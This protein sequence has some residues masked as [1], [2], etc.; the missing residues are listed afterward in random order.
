[1]HPSLYGRL[2]AASSA[3]VTL[4]NGGGETLFASLAAEKGG[5]ALRQDAVLPAFGRVTVRLPLDGA[6]PVTSLLLRFDSW[7]ITGKTA[8][9]L[10][11]FRYDAE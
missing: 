7:R 2:G 6:G 10:G 8:V 9:W 5:K 1:L 4:Y 3:S 11:G